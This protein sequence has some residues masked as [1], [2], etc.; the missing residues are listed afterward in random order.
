[1]MLP[2][3]QHYRQPIMHFNSLEAQGDVFA[4]EVLTRAKS[5]SQSAFIGQAID[6]ELGLEIDRCA[7]RVAAAM[8]RDDTE[9]ARPC[10][11]FNVFASTLMCREFVAELMGYV[12]VCPELRQRL[13]I[14]VT[15]HFCRFSWAKLMARCQEIE[16]HGIVVALDDIGDGI[17]SLEAANLVPHRLEKF[18][19]A[20]LELSSGRDMRHVIVERIESRRQF[21]RAFQTGARMFQGDHFGAAS[22]VPSDLLDYSEQSEISQ[23][24]RGAEFKSGRQTGM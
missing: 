13:G 6:A 10:F 2:S 21:E 20:N 3:Y 11:F 18:A 8:A 1:M 24:E 17:F 4:W 9:G 14:E 19:L 7:M 22:R 15:E 12:D 23:W 5:Q 16:N